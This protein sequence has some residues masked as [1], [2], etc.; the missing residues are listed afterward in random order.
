MTHTQ[1]MPVYLCV[2]ALQARIQ[3]SFYTPVPIIFT[4]AQNLSHYHTGIAAGLSCPSYTVWGQSK[5]AV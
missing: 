1:E 3:V 2:V 4:F 5:P